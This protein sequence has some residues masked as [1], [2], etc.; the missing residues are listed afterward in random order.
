M[1]RVTKSDWGLLHI[2]WPSEIVDVRMRDVSLDGISV[3]CGVALLVF[4]RILPLG[5]AVAV[6][7]LMFYF[8]E[9]MDLKRF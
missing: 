8:K 9:Y 5:L 1:P 3:Y 7:I 6:A 2:D 4:G